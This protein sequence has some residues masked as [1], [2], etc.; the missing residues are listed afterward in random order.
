MGENEWVDNAR[1]KHKQSDVDDAFGLEALGGKELDTDVALARIGSVRI[2]RFGEKFLGGCG[3]GKGLR[4][5]SHG[6]EAL[7]GLV[8][9][10]VKRLALFLFAF[11][12]KGCDSSS[13]VRN[14]LVATRQCL[15]HPCGSCP[16]FVRRAF[17]NRAFGDAELFGDVGSFGP[18]FDE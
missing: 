5:R 2:D 12:P 11:G 9:S 3:F 16:A 7:E 14:V 6:E 10:L 4:D 15:S 18:R 17:V 8:G 13:R 1:L